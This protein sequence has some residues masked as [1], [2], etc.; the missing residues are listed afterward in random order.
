MKIKIIFVLVFLLGFFQSTFAAGINEAQYFQ[1]EHK[2]I[3]YATVNEVFDDWINNLN[4]SMYGQK[5]CAAWVSSAT[6]EGV[7]KQIENMSDAEF[8]SYTTFTGKP[9]SA[10]FIIGNIV[11][12]KTILPLGYIYLIFSAIILVISAMKTGGGGMKYHFALAAF[13]ICLSFAVSMDLQFAASRKNA[14]TNLQAFEIYLLGKAYNFSN[15]M[16]KNQNLNQRIYVKPILS[17]QLDYSAPQ[18]RDFIDF[19]MCAKSKNVTDISLNLND[20]ND[21]Y[22]EGQKTVKGCLGTFTFGNNKEISRLIV[23]NKL[24]AKNAQDHIKDTITQAGNSLIRKTNEELNKIQV[25]FL[26]SDSQVKL[27]SYVDYY[28]L[29]KVLSEFYIKQLANFEKDPELSGRQKVICANNSEGGRSYLRMREI[30]SDKENTVKSCVADNKSKSLVEYIASIYL[31]S[32][33]KQF[34]KYD[35][36][37][38][39]S[40]P[41]VVMKSSIEVSQGFRTVVDNFTFKFNM[42]ADE[43]KDNDLISSSNTLTLTGNISNNSEF[44]YEDFEKLLYNYEN[45]YNKS[46][47]REEKTYPILSMVTGDSGFLGTAEFKTCSNVWNRYLVVDGYVCGGFADSF[48]NLGDRIIAFGVEGAAHLGSSKIT[49]A[50]TKNRL[51]AGSEQTVAKQMV[52]RAGAALG[53]NEAVKA[54]LREPGNSAFGEVSSEKFANNEAKALMV[55]QVFLKPVVYD[56]ALATVGQTFIF[57]GLSIKFIYILVLIFAMYGLVKFQTFTNIAI[58]FSNTFVINYTHAE[59]DY[60]NVGVMKILSFI[61]RLTIYA[62]AMYIGIFLAKTVIYLAI[63]FFVKQADI[64]DHINAKVIDGIFDFTGVVDALFTY[65]ITIF[66]SWKITFSFMSEF[67]KIGDKIDNLGVGLNYDEVEGNSSEKLHRALKGK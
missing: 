4:C 34:Y 39:V 37:G 16:N 64:A 57:S 63:S 59:Q 31:E 45:E 25:G 42:L 12:S 61:A 30:V 50:Y 3:A 58:L 60:N 7:V 15:G 11:T 8:N 43:V 62:Y 52:I 17:P 27:Q 32:Q 53:V 26:S 67:G 2:N 10:F 44:D 65:G 49:Q 24:S 28:N 13:T 66:I 51:L 36:I 18:M 41:F 5:G 47:K 22:Y 35:K 56:N 1:L 9:K 6:T 20:S 19:I 55:G 23:R 38:I 46:D 33:L 48:M 29:P 21:F 14:M 40:A 54:M